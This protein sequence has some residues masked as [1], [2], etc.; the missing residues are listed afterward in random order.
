MK[1]KQ[2]GLLKV[3][4]TEN[5]SDLMIKFTDLATL[6]KLCAIMGLELRGG[7]S[8]LAPEVAKGAGKEEVNCVMDVDDLGNGEHDN[9][10]EDSRK[11]LHN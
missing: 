5:P 6:D 8:A 7:R 4:G 9:G 2:I 10:T 3:K 11:Q 1:D